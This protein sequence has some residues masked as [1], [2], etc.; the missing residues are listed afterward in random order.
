MEENPYAE[1]QDFSNELAKKRERINL[2][3]EKIQEEEMKAKKKLDNERWRREEHR[4]NEEL[5]YVDK[6]R[7]KQKALQ[8]K[9]WEIDRKGHGKTEKDYEMMGKLRDQED[10]IEEILQSVF[11]G[12][13]SRYAFITDR[14]LKKYSDTNED[15]L[16]RYPE[17]SVEHK[18]PVL[19]DGWSS[20]ED[21]LPDCEYK[22]SMNEYDYWRDIDWERQP[23]PSKEEI[24]SKLPSGKHSKYM[25]D[26]VTMPEDE[27]E[28][29]LL[30][31]KD[32]EDLMKMSPKDRKHY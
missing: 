21:C 3:G 20:I 15:L 17:A 10:R 22:K 16:K 8:E 1:T 2:P 9:R 31:Q 14:L 28:T 18:C 30:Q 4:H 19:V 13:D 25:R 24:L 7:A 32:E 27:W 5:K 26:V 29:K 11:T 12:W 23:P 6:L